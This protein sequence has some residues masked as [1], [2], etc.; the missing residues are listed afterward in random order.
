MIELTK[1]EALDT[2][3]AL[4]KLEGALI[5]SNASADVLD[6]LCEPVKI[7]TAKLLDEDAQC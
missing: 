5:T 3:K 7:L 1:K 2:L 4:S 6:L